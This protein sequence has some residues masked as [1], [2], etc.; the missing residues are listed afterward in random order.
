MFALILRHKVIVWTNNLHKKLKS[1]YANYKIGMSSYK[2]AQF[3]CEFIKTRRPGFYSHDNFSN[4]LHRAII[5]E[6]D[7][8]DEN[9]AESSNRSEKTVIKPRTP[10]IWLNKLGY[11]YTDIKK[12]VFLNEHERPDVVEYQA[13]FLKELEALG[14]YLVKFRD[15]GSMEEKVYP[16]DCAVNGPN[17]RPII[18]I[19][20]D[21]GIFSANYH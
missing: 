12:G 9:S 20:H 1:I 21:E 8:E 16:S 14:P 2:L 18:L 17:K 6:D 19:T 3:V 5:E 10:P 11:Q 13:Q 7:G 15:D 4:Q